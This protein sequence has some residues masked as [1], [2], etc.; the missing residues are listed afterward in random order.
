MGADS[1][2]RRGEVPSFASL[3][4][5]R[6]LAYSTVSST[7]EDATDIEQTSTYF[8]TTSNEGDTE[9][10]LNPASVHSSEQPVNGD[11]DDLGIDSV[12]YSASSTSSIKPSLSSLR[13][14]K[15]P[16]ID[17]TTLT[18]DSEAEPSI[19]LK[20]QPQT[21]VD[22]SIVSLPPTVRHPPI[23]IEDT[24][25]SV[26]PIGLSSIG[27]PGSEGQQLGEVRGGYLAEFDPPL[28]DK[29]T[30]PICQL[31]LREPVQGPCG[32]RFCRSCIEPMLG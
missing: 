1:L 29:H 16:A 19:A 22:V 7:D 9:A 14:S 5:E 18:E 32:D 15:P 3:S 21:S 13:I 17:Y 24:E 26:S 20:S 31:A 27:S 23:A 10:S 8:S 4:S 25:G 2:V 30:C 6:P 11:L 28:V 12:D